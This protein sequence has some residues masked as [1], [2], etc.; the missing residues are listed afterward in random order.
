MER[1]RV[2]R[3]IRERK[4]GGENHEIRRKREG[5]DDSGD[6][7]KNIGWMKSTGKEYKEE[8]KIGD[9]H[10]SGIIH[11]DIKAENVFL[12]SLGVVKIGDLGFSTA[13][14]PDEALSTFC[15]S[16]PYAAP[17]LFKDDS[18]VG[19]CVDVWALGVLLYFMVCGTM[20]FRAETVGKLKRKILEGVYNV[21]DFLTESC[22]FLIKQIL[23]PVPSDRFTIPEIMRSLWLEGIEFPK[24]YKKYEQKPS[25]S[26]SAGSIEEREASKALQTFGIPTDLIENCPEDSKNQVTG[27]YRIVLHQVQ[28]RNLERHVAQLKAARKEREIMRNNTLGYDGPTTKVKTAPPKSKLCVIL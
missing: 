14:M 26:P 25:L 18:Y 9:E 11:R 27:T 16:P 23:R 10:E 2:E 24:P 5:E 19:S 22:R 15:G 7:V 20:P 28:R 4:K 13:S 17:E 1:I 8:K 6:V 3:E 21:P 12:S